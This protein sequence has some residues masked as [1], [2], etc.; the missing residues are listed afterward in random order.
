MRGEG[1]LRSWGSFAMHAM[2][3]AIIHAQRRRS[4]YGLA[5]L[6]PLKPCARKN[7]LYYL[8]SWPCSLC[9]MCAQ[10][11]TAD[12]VCSVAWKEWHTHTVQAAGG[13]ENKQWHRN[14]ESSCLT[15]RDAQVL[16]RSSR[17]VRWEDKCVTFLLGVCIGV[18]VD[19]PLG[20]TTSSVLL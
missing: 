16:S 15:G 5:G 19:L 1:E 9:G 14:Q 20:A 10:E 17:N 18:C 2:L 13:T 3:S 8:G 6:W 11:G 7:S 4:K 12:L